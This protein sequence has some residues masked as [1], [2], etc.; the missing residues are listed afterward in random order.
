MLSR[1]K[2][3]LVL[4]LALILP[5]HLI[6]CGHNKININFA[7]SSFKKIIKFPSSATEYLV[8]TNKLPGVSFQGKLVQYAGLLPVFGS[9]N[10]NDT[11]FFWYF[12]SENKRSNDLVQD[13]SLLA[14]HGPFSGFD[15]KTKKL[16]NNPHSWHQDAHIVYV[17]QPF[18]VGFSNLTGQTKV[19]NETQVGETIFNFLVN[20]FRVF[21][22]LR[23]KDIYLAA[24]SILSNGE[25]DERNK[26]RLKGI[27]INSA[28]IDQYFRQ[29]VA[30]AIPYA[31]EQNL[32]N[33]TEQ[34]SLQALLDKCEPTIGSKNS[35]E[36]TGAEYTTGFG[37]CDVAI[38]ALGIIY[39]SNPCFSIHDVRYNCSNP[40]PPFLL[41]NS[42]FDYV[43][44]LQN[45]KLLEQIHMP[46]N[47][48]PWKL[49]NEILRP[50]H[51]LVTVN[52][53][54]R[55]T[56]HI[57]VV[58]WSGDKD[59]LINHIGTEFAIGNMSWGGETGF[60]NNQLQPILDKDNNKVIGKL[61]T[62]RNLTYVIV[63]D[64]GHLV[65]IDQPKSS[66]F[67]LQKTVLDDPLKLEK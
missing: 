49:C 15:R 8:D 54:P 24:A 27:S 19:E 6:R 39:K 33:A 36:A 50:D 1:I 44:F 59:P 17:D 22:R 42:E 14:E 43:A 52:I 3:F 28:V 12:E 57:K 5:Q 25:I 32:I 18:G 21:P 64:A 58:I 23:N 2:V 26:F 65:S 67:I 63:H 38:A 61:H 40:A 31:V 48:P 53:I 34:A 16:T 55:L 13:A 4:L 7:G 10:P 30:A 46:A 41:V 29:V 45:P 35:S 9:K 47:S 37:K 62:E 66:R 51:S 11:L 60:K 20:F 56:E